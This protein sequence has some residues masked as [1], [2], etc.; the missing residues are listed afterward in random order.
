MSV[1]LVSLWM[2]VTSDTFMNVASWF[3]H[4]VAVPSNSGFD[5]SSSIAD[6][7]VSNGACRGE[8]GCG[9]RRVRHV[10]MT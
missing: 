8:G 9:G 10:R 3:L 4:L 5:V 7:G 6:C 2:A 1:R